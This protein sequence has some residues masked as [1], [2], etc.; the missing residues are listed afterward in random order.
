MNMND[1][2]NPDDE[3][4]DPSEL[5]PVD[6]SNI[7]PSS[8]EEILARSYS[9]D[10]QVAEARQL[11]DKQIADATV[12]Q[13]VTEIATALASQGR[14]KPNTAVF[15]AI[16]KNSQDHAEEAGK[17]VALRQK[18]IAD[19]IKGQAASKR[20]ES[21][22]DFKKDQFKETQRHHKALETLARDK[23]GAKA[24]QLDSK[25]TEAERAVDKDYAKDYNDFTQGGAIRAQQG[26]AK[27][28]A[29]AKEIQDDNGLLQSGG[30]RFAK[31]L[32]E[33]ARSRDAVRRRDSAIN[34]A[35]KTLKATF[36]SQISDAERESV[37]KEFYNDALS[38][39]ENAKILNGKIKELEGQLEGQTTKAMHYEN[40]RTLKGFKSG[41]TSASAA[42]GFPRKV[43]NGAGKIATVSNEAEAQA[44][45][46]KGF[47]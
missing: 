12:N 42:G 21:E 5:P 6:P 40:N 16:K 25:L 29:L 41:I 35:N 19:Y 1:Y 44:A 8:P 14:V 17:D 46:A 2:F 43:S 27:L 26:I 34:E 32:P 11:R 23:E 4:L 38:N 15:D 3:E 18:T 7:P 22:T 39:E 10:P 24:E 31:E 36:G 30:G 9:V 45:A 28:K 20:L 47:H 37:A 33:W 13:G